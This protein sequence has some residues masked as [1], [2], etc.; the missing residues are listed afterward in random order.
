MI[1][2][3]DEKRQLQKLKAPKKEVFADSYCVPC[4]ALKQI[5]NTGKKTIQSAWKSN[6]S[7]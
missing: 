6:I 7:M 5:T 1:N 3:T 4:S 2:K